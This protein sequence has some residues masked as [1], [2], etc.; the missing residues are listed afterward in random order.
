MIKLKNLLNEAV[1]KSKLKKIYDK[2][3]KGDD[4]TIK[5]GSSVRSGN[6]GDFIVK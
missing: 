2:L 4:V 6:S 3:N 5:Y 1:D